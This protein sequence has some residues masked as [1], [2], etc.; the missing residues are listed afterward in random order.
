MVLKMKINN[1]S[2]K[3]PKCLTYHVDQH[4]L[5]T[6]LKYHITQTIIHTSFETTVSK[7]YHPHNHKQI[8]YNR[9]MWAKKWV[10]FV[11]Y[12]G[13]SS[14]QC[15]ISI[16]TVWETVETLVFSYNLW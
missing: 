11:S 1:S 13:E 6:S 4:V 12:T 9:D 7:V 2:A 14:Y 3:K 5:V 10:N 16:G 8:L 15:F